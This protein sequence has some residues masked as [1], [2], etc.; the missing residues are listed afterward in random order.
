LTILTGPNNS[1]KSTVLQAIAL[2]FEVFRRCLNTENWTL[3]D[4]GRVVAE[5]EFLPVNQ[6]KDLWYKQIWKPRNGRDR[7]V[8]VGIRFSNGFRCTSRIRFMY[9]FLNV[10]LESAEPAPD[11][12]LLRSIASIAPVVLLPASPGPSS[13]EEHVSLAQVHRIINIREPNRVLR[14]VLLLLQKEEYRD[15]RNFVEEVLRRYFGVSLQEISFDESRNLEIRSPLVEGDYSVD[16]V[17]AGSG[18]NQILQIA[19]I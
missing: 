1:G 3:S 2:F 17:S 18:L 14:N 11:L 5:F 8:R 4:T 7:Y 15:A 6:P 19:A 16:V 12:H 13:H 9:G 10:G